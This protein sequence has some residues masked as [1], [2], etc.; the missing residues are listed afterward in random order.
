MVALRY[1]SPSSPL[2][3][4]NICRITIKNNTSP[5]RFLYFLIKTRSDALVIIDPR[6][7]VPTKILRF[8]GARET[9]ISNF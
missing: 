1:A 2:V 3:Y 5:R 9:F 6:E 8:S 7:K 4:L